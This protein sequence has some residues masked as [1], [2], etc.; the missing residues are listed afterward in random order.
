MG[1]PDSVAGPLRLVEDVRGIDRL[2]PLDTYQSELV[3]TVRALLADGADALDVTRFI[4]DANDALTVRLL[5]LAEA[6]LGRPPVR[7]SWLALGSHG[8]GEQVLSSD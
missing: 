6:E 3:T 7:Y 2:E 4:A 5:G 1:R 8:R